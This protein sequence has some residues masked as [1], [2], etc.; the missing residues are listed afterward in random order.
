M[1]R[2]IEVSW[3]LSTRLRLLLTLVTAVGWLVTPTR[4]AYF[5]QFTRKELDHDQ[6]YDQTGR[7]VRCVP[8]F[9][10]TAYGKL[11]IL[12]ISWSVE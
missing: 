12:I 11:A 2:V 4:G 6:C 1:H 5:S 8:D 10:N 7:P 9:I 3:S